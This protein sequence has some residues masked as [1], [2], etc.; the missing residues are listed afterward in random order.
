MS[1]ITGARPKEPARLAAISAITEIASSAYSDGARR[2]ESRPR[3]A[4]V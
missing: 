3:A 2:S 1:A 4:S